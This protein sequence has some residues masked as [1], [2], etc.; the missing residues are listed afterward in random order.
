VPSNSAVEFM[1]C[2]AYLDTVAETGCDP[3]FGFA[4]ADDSFCLA[5]GAAVNEGQ[6]TV[7]C[8]GAIDCPDGF[9]CAAVDDPEV[10]QACVP[11]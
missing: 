10:A 11:E 1:T 7:P 4:C 6:C 8:G 5:S 9:T 3:R 2:A